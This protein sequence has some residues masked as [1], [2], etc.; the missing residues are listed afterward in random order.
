LI[1][2]FSTHSRLDV[3]AALALPVD[4]IGLGPVF[5]SSTKPTPRALLGPKGA[6]EAAALF[7]PR[8]C[9]PIGGIDLSGAGLLSLAGVRRAAVSSAI[10]SSEDPGSA[11]REMREALESEAADRRGRRP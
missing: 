4:Y 8:P 5:A 11:A 3:Q 1:V 6:A 2:G 9:F 10:L 7:S